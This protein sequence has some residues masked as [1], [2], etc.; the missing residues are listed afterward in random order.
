MPSGFTP[1][2]FTSISLTEWWAMGTAPCASS[3]CTSIVR[4][5]N[6]GHSFVGIPAP[7]AALGYRNGTVPITTSTVTSLRFADATDGFAFG[8]A[9]FATHDG[10]ASWH[11]VALRGKVESLVTGGGYAYA[12]VSSCASASP[13]CASVH[14]ERSPVG[15]SSWSVVPTPVPIGPFASL[16]VHG[17]DLWVLGNEVSPGANTVSLLA[18]TDSGASFVADRSS[19]YRGLPGSV[20]AASSTTVW[21]F[22]PTGMLGTLSVSTD[23]GGA[24]SSVSPSRVPGTNGQAF[25][26][27]TQVKAASGSEAFV[28]DPASTALARTTDTGRSFSAVAPLGSMAWFGFSTSTRGYAL[29]FTSHSTANPPEQLWVTNDA[30]ATWQP[31]HF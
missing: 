6:G 30:A 15:S 23:R 1:V 16:A 4:T 3:P 10:G 31:V 9:L 27:S 24:F 7:R 29:T 13:S 12:V 25:S 19:C 5:T 26:N 17:P 22:C 8:G 11:Q 21:T 28:S 2:S 18:S 14:L 20:S